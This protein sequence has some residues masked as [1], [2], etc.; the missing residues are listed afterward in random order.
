MYRLYNLQVKIICIEKQ[1]AEIELGHSDC[2]MNI[3]ED[4]EVITM[5]LCMP[6]TPYCL[7]FWHNY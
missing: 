7:L 4:S 5:Y 1:T 2:C 6:G 3:L